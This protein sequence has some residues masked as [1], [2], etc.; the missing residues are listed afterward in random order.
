MS[1]QPIQ[2][3]KNIIGP[4]VAVDAVLLT[5][6]D[7][8][9]CVL[10]LK[11]KDPDAHF[12]WVLPGGM[13]SLEEDLKDSVE[14]ILREK[15]NV[16][17]NY[18]EQL[19]TFGDPARDTRGRVISVSY[20]ALVDFKD[21]DLQITSA[22]SGIQWFP[23]KELPEMGYDH[24]QIVN[25]ALERVRNKLAYSNIAGHLLPKE[26]TLAQLQEVYEGVL[27]QELDK[28]N[29]LRKVLSLDL[30]GETGKM[31]GDVP[32]RPAKLYRF[33]D[34]RYKEIEVL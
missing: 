30:V 21:F 8:K 27:D 20:F 7:E 15:T 28:R 32:H 13:V 18:L 17:L 9:L 2:Q 12:N 16:N 1:N 25:K 33:R 23:V 22:Y 24:P 34:K 26:F 14:R 31:Q 11:A 6:K 19:Y 29:F 10:L 3:L 4:A 5:I